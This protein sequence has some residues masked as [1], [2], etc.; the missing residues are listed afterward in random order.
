MII[1]QGIGGENRKNK[2]IYL[3]FSDRFL[4]KILTT[5]EIDK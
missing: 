1:L 2:K 4:K 3:N 5:R